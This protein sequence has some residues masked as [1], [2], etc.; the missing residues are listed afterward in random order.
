M[1]AA[2]AE[3]AASRRLAEARRQ[4][5]DEGDRRARLDLERRQE[6]VARD[7]EAAHWPVRIDVGDPAP[8]RVEHLDLADQ[9]ARPEGEAAVGSLHADRTFEHEQQLVPGLADPHD[10]L[11]IRELALA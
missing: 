10:R 6:L 8:A 11:A 4:H 2:A 7:R 9:L 3:S 5:R 1:R